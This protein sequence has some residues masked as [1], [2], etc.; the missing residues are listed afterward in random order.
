MESHSLGSPVGSRIKFSN[1]LDYAE[2]DN[3][4]EKIPL[5]CSGDVV[6]L[7]IRSCHKRAFQSTPFFHCFAAL[8]LSIALLI[9]KLHKNRI[10]PT[11]IYGNYKQGRLICRLLRRINSQKMLAVKMEDRKKSS[12]RKQ[13]NCVCV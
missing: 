3:L 13:I 9:Y 2:R 5:I 8:M 10:I 7:L 11:C 1:L 6:Y 12:K 4:N